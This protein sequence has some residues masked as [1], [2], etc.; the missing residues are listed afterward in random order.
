MEYAIGPI[1]VSFLACL[2]SGPILIP[3]LQKLRFGQVIRADGP[4]SHLK[5]AGTPTSGGLI[6]LLGI[7]AGTA[8][9]TRHYDPNMIA[10]GICF[11][12][13]G[14]IGFLDDFLKINRKRSLGLRAWQ[15]IVLQLGLSLVIA[16]YAYNHIGT[17]LRLPFTAAEWDLGV[18]YVPFVVL[19]LIA[20]V[21]SVNLT[22]GLDG[23]ASGVSLVYFAAYALIFASVSSPHSEGMLILCGALVG[24]CLGFLRFNV[25][26]ARIIMGDTGSLAL[27]GAVAFAAII[28]RTALWLPVMGGCFMISSLSDIIQVGSYKLRNKKRVFR[29]A[30]IHHHF[31]LMGVPETR[32]VAMYMIA[33]AILCL[34]GLWAM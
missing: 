4:Q 17:S 19:V 15:K 5:K 3:L 32:I 24:A 13:F 28:S 29:M 27:G 10:A 14:L 23:L 8:A 33:T 11:F 20:S 22:D 21:N 34:L 30:P 16:L 12:G 31:E 7:M 2:A 18:W 1:I 25:F 26:P 6:I 9:F